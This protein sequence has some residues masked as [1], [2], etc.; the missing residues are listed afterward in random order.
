MYLDCGVYCVTLS[1]GG[2]FAPSQGDLSLT[3]LTFFQ[4]MNKLTDLPYPISCCPLKYLFNKT[5]W[6]RVMLL[7]L[8]I[9]LKT[10][11]MLGYLHYQQSDS[12]LVVARYNFSTITGLYAFFFCFVFLSHDTFFESQVLK[13][14]LIFHC[15]WCHTFN[16]C[17]CFNM[18][19]SLAFKNVHTYIHVCYIYD[20]IQE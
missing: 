6:G 18:V 17:K 7:T 2:L 14:Y 10:V 5:L 3:L 12:V 15:R 16:K 9:D 20:Y 13:A 1:S 4:L 8:F 11:S 19:T